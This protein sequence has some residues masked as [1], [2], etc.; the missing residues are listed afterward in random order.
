MFNVFE[1]ARPVEF[2]L[3][4]IESVVGIEVPANRIGMECNR[5]DVEEVSGNKLEASV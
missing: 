1:H 2:N 5:E 3:H 4:A